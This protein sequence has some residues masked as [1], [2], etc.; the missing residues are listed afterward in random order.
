VQ[1]GREE[2]KVMVRYPARA[3]RSLAALETMRVRLPDGSEVPFETV[4]EARH[5]RGHST[6]SRS[7]RRRTLHVTAEVDGEVTSAN[8]V[9]GDLATRVLPE[10]VSSRSGLAW[11][12][13]GE[14]REQSETLSGLAR[15]FA[16]AL[17]VIY[18][19]MAI[20]FRSYLQPLIVMSA[21]PFGMVGA[22]LGH[23]LVGM[24]MNVLSMCG[25]VA[26]AGVVVNDNLVLVDYINRRRPRTGGIFTAVHEAGVARFR[27]I[28]LT[29]L[30]T[31]AGLTPLMLETS[32]QAQ[33]LIPM[34]I[35]LAFGVL[36]STSVS[37]VLVPCLYL[38]LEDVKAAAARLGVGLAAG[39]QGRLPA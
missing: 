1:R 11:S 36:F 2:V 31:F 16:L 39:G 18:G 14:A 28:L 29:S 25:M 34:A 20:P 12:F 32:V 8:E 15:G 4:A 37:L 30:T 3:R 13:E 19:L 33:F 5:G 10:L 17:L 7:D 23:L 38:I 6:I 22:F 35:S 26:L 24:D 21:I 9:N 27:P